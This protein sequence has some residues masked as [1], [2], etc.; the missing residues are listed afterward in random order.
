M[1]TRETLNGCGIDISGDAW[2]P[3]RCGI[4][5]IVVTR[6]TLN[7]CGIDIIVVTRE[8]LNGCGIDII[9]VTLSYRQALSRFCSFQILPPMD[10]DSFT[11]SSD[12]MDTPRYHPRISVDWI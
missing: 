5:I 8:T 9:V 1:V 10:I 7:G 2:D 6:E 3:E 11:E 4:D 12:A